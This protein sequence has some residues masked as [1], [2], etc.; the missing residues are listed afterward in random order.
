ML[1]SGALTVLSVKFVASCEAKIKSLAHALSAR[2]YNAARTAG[3]CAGRP[4]SMNAR[5]K[6][7]REYL[8]RKATLALVSS[9]A[10]V[11][12]VWFGLNAALCWFDRNIAYC[13]P[14]IFGYGFVCSLFA[15]LFRTAANKSKCLPYVPPVK[16]QIANLPFCDVL[17]RS[18]EQPA[19]SAEELL[20]AARPRDSKPEEELLRADSRTT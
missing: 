4:Q 20:R 12:A 16:A 11:V 17:V 1:L 2:D 18:S 19:A 10:A 5:A 15:R 3:E 8:R 7:R 14:Y 13:L 6:K 9:A